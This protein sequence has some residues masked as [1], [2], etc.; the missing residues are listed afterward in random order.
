MEKTNLIQKIIEQ[1]REYEVLFI[2]S[3]F[4]SPD[5]AL[6]EYGYISHDFFHTEVLK[7]YWKILKESN[8]D[9]TRAARESGC[10]SLIL[11][12]FEVGFTRTD[13]N[14]EKMLRY[15]AELK[16]LEVVNRVV[17]AVAED[18][19]EKATSL[20]SSLDI[21]A[22]AGKK[23]SAKHAVD[24]SLEFI[25]YLNRRNKTIKTGIPALDNALGGLP[26]HHISVLASR[27]S[28]GK[29]ALSLQI[30]RNVAARGERV[31][32]I[33]TESTSNDL[34]SRAACGAL[35][36]DQRD[37]MAGTLS[38]LDMQR[39]SQI[40]SQ[41]MNQYDDKLWIDSESLTLEEIHL[42]VARVRPV[43]IVLDHLEEMSL[44]HGETRVEFYGVVMDYLK[45]LSKLYDTAVLLVHQ[46]R[47]ENEMRSSRRPVLSD[48][49]WSGAVE[50]KAAQV[51]MLHREDLYEEENKAGIS[52]VLSELWIRKNRFGPRDS[53]VKLL[54]NLKKQ[55]YFDKR[56]D[57]GD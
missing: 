47:R 7:N 15:S 38:E 11:D 53:L 4:N 43:L 54:Y 51:L 1:K 36:I 57:R 21:D 10:M 50:Q 42:Q 28:V 52:E 30:A 55:W 18:D 46:L 8:G 49:K 22:F 23:Q 19:I 31:L 24:V 20:M 3:L 41:L 48:L 25:D 5:V 35:E 56:D 34:W 32:Y 40:S 12:D 14:A 27:T 37:L 26:F 6:Q 29:T 17:R 13:L 39:L 2:A 45:K 33:S 44:P 16:L 9:S